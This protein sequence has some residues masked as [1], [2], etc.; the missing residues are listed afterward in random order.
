MPSVSFVG[1][2]VIQARAVQACTQAVAEAA[3]DLVGK[4]QA[5][6]RVATGA[7]RAGLHVE[8]VTP[9]GDGATAIVA[10]GGPSSEYDVYQHEGT[11][12]M[13]GTKFLE[14][15]VMQDGEALKAHIANAA[16]SVF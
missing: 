9:T 2:A 5:L 15:P 8:S 10:T 6:T 16:N 3:E 1:V 12:K 13:S 14:T 7:E 11:Y 4:A